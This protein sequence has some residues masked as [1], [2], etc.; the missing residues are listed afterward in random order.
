MDLA[1]ADVWHGVGPCL[2]LHHADLHQVLLAGAKDVPIRWGHTVESIV[3][4]DDHVRVSL[5]DGTRQGYDLVLGA[6]G[7]HSS[8][9]R[10][11]FG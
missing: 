10:M 7:V 1:M 8:V 9:R 6:D 3:D 11:I 2:A 4:T 5:S